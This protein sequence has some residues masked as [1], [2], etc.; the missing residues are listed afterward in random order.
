[1]VPAGPGYVR[2]LKESDAMTMFEKS[3]TIGDVI[4]WIATLPMLLLSIVFGLVL[5]R[6][7]RSYQVMFDSMGSELPSITVFLVSIPKLIIPIPI[8]VLALISTWVMIKSVS[9]LNKCII[10]ILCACLWSMYIGF[11]FIAIYYPLLQL[12]S[13]VRGS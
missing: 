9:D 7:V 6:A 5:P 1:M 10:P 11:I 12:Q 13:A 4:G 2:Q 3:A 8:F